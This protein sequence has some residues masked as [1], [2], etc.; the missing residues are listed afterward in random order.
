P[1]AV[2]VGI[3]TQKSIA[4]CVSRALG[5]VDAMR[6]ARREIKLDFARHLGVALLVMVISFIAAGLVSS[7]GIPF[8]FG[9]RWD[10]RLHLPPLLFAPAQIVLSIVQNAVS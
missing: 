10:R 6:A 9:R 3:W 5:A 7:F 4:V 1:T 8:S 2:L